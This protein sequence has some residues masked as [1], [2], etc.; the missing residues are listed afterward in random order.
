[1]ER[2]GLLLPPVIP[3]FSMFLAMTLG[4]ASLPLTSMSLD[5]VKWVSSLLVPG[6]GVAGLGEQAHCQFEGSVL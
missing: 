3:G 1:M 4:T 5:F 2:I 6:R